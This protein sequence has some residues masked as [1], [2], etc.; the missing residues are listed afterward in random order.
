[1][2]P[3]GH[4]TKPLHTERDREIIVKHGSRNRQRKGCMREREREEAEN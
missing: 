3:S 1:M 2:G 4:T